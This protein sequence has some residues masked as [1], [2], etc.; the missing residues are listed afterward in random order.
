MTLIEMLVTIAVIGIGVVGIA[1]GFT[2]V[3]RSSGET[4]DQATLD[5]AAHYLADYM[6][7]DAD[8]AYLAC[9]TSYAA[10]STTDPSA[11]SAAYLNDGV[12]WPSSFPVAVSSPNPTPGYASLETCS[13]STDDYGVQE[14]TITVTDHGIS[15]TQ[16]VWKDDLS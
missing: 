11:A 8:V 6:Q 7:S 14:I 9:A 5:G 10:P 15:V 12:S 2:A 4:Q 16:V 1:Y 3:V 13:A